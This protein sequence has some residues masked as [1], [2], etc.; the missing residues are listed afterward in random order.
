MSHTPAENLTERKFKFLPLALEIKKILKVF[1]KEGHAA[2][3]K[4]R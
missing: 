4:C 1:K 3:D 2:Y